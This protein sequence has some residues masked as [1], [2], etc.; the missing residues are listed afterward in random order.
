MEM[1]DESMR[2]SCIIDEV[3]R[4]IHIGL[5]CVQKGRVER[6]TMWSV[7]LMLSSETALKKPRSPGF[8]MERSTSSK[9][10]SSNKDPRISNDCT[11]TLLEGR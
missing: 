10:N 4:C 11:F 5:L 2:T 3:S 7:M 9:G 8:Y 1:V 6:A